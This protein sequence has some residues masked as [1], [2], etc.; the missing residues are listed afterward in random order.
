MQRKP[1]WR[2]ATACSPSV[3]PE[4]WKD[5]VKKLTSEGR[6]RSDPKDPDRLAENGATAC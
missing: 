6:E 3:A 2:C 4:A 5:G 1:G